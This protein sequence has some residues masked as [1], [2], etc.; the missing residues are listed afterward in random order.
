MLLNRPIYAAVMTSN[1]Y[2]EFG[3]RPFSTSWEFNLTPLIFEFFFL[4]KSNSMAFIFVM[5]NELSTQNIQHCSLA[6]FQLW[7]DIVLKPISKHLY[8]VYL[9]PLHTRCSWKSH[10]MTARK[11]IKEI[12]I[13]TVKNDC[14]RGLT[15]VSDNHEI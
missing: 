6:A 2:I 7:H 13:E 12:Q 5:H 8:S 11:L 14:S 15:A 10:G 9:P 3:L 1:K 4:L